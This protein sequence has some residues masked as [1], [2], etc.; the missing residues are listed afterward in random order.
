MDKKFITAQEANEKAKAY[1]A[2]ERICEQIE[3]AAEKGRFR[4]FFGDITP[5]DK[6]NLEALGYTVKEIDNFKFP[7]VISWE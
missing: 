4:T 2:I 7:I 3:R 5:K 6:V 1:S